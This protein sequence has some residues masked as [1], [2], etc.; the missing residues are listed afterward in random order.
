MRAAR[1]ET[2]QGEDTR[3]EKGIK[4]ITWTLTRRGALTLGLAGLSSLIVGDEA[5][6]AP[7]N[8]YRRLGVAFGTQVAI[9]LHAPN[10]NEAEAA[11]ASG[12][13]EIRA[14]DRLA[15]LTRPDSE[16]YRLNRDGALDEPSP[17]LLE[18]LRTA[19]A[20]HVATRGAFDVTIQPMWLAMDAA[21]KRGGW[22]TDAE[23]RE[24][25]ALVDQKALS[26]DERRVVFDRPGMALTLNSLA[27]GLA[28]DRVGAALARLGVAHAMFDT[29]VLGAQ[30]TKP[31]GRPW[32]A[33]IRHPRDEQR[34]VGYARVAGCL[35]TSGD[36]A[37]FWTPDY[38]RNH[39]VDPRRGASP[40]DFSSVTIFARSGLVADALSTAAFLVGAEE[41]EA[42]VRGCGAEALFVDKAGNV[43]PTPGFPF[44]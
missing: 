37:Y 11:F 4:T 36:Y 12:F 13:A 25:R 8:E 44:V 10:E 41:A 17:A 30:G 26:F 22:L 9:T 29:D 7:L 5:G 15:S 16:V 1:V 21:A 33:R 34:S 42:L 23:M 39:I 32:V 38:S 18:M 27:R 31:D 19:D 6:R 43:T 24:M 20:M 40:M 35:A 28:A 2:S 14:I 3:D